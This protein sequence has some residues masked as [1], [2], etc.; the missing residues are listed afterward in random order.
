MRIKKSGM[1][2]LALT[3]CVC[4]AACGAE[5]NSVG[6]QATPEDAV[7]AFVQAASENNAEAVLAL[8]AADSIGGGFDFAAYADRLSAIPGVPAAAAP[9]YELYNALNA[10]TQRGAYATQVKAFCYGF[11]VGEDL[12]APQNISDDSQVA[13]FISAVD[14]KSL[15]GL[16]VRE[17][18]VPY[19]NT[20]NAEETQAMEAE[21][22][23]IYG[24]NEQA[25]RIALLELDGGL[26]LCGF[27][28][29]RYSD[30]WLVY[31]LNSTVA[32]QSPTHPVQPITE[33]AY[34]LMVE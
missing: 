31:S 1:T 15:A 34:R 21:S 32:N 24:A 19:P 3:L 16:A 20:Y 30:G 17:V 5:K 6:P 33:D 12:T 27:T 13:N 11:F 4:M 2:L 25:Q 26:Y 10:A 18:H 7:T 28:L 22:A 9:D 8:S 29:L 23:A 14:P